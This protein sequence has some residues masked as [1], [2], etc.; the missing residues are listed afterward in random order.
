MSSVI[1]TSAQ[2]IIAQVLD[3]LQS[4]GQ[5]K[6][7]NLMTDT[8]Q[9]GIDNA[10]GIGEGFTLVPGTS[11][12]SVTVE[13]AGIAYDPLANRI[14]ISSSDTTLYN[15]ANPTT[16]TNDGTGTF[17]LTPQSTGCVNVPLTG[18]SFNYLW[19]DYL[20]TIDVTAF[21]LNKITQA[22]I[23]YEATDGYNIQVTTVNTP[24]DANSI[25]LGTINLS[26]IS[27]GIIPSSVIS[28]IGRQYFNILP[29]IVPITTA[30]AGTNPPDRTPHYAPASTYT[31]EAHIKAVGTGSGQSP[32]N[33]HNLSLADLGVSVI[34]TVTAHRQLEHQT[35]ASSGNAAANAII[36]GVPGTPSPSIS[37]MAASIN[38]VNPGSDYLT[39]FQLLS[40]E[41]AIINGTAYNVTDIFGSVPVNANVFF[42]NTSGTYNVYY[43]SNVNAFSLSTSDI[44]SD[45]TKLWLCTITYTYVGSGPSDHNS[46]SS[47]IDRRRIGSTTHLLQRWLTSARPGSGSTAAASGEFGFNLTTG[48][49][50]YW[51]GSVWQQPVTSSSNSIVPTGALLPFAGAAA[52]AG[53]LMANGSSQLVA[54]FP[55]LFAV[56]GYTYGG[57]GGNFNV[58][59]MTNYVPIGAGSIAPF[60]TTFGEANHTLT[61]AEIPA[62]THSVSDPSHV[63]TENRSGTGG[64]IFGIGS[65]ANPDASGNILTNATTQSAPTGI[66]I[67]SSGGSGGSHNNVQ[68]SLG[69]SYI[70]KT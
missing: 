5:S 27:S 61:T 9:S 14:F 40:S 29:N 60:G 68:P 26:S 19:I 56:I 25:F 44:S 15:S 64:S 12:L 51:D 48:L 53:F 28:Q 18:G 31:L 1:F 66:S 47:L 70:I 42:P 52:P 21:T 46:L 45:V 38:I 7:S 8:F 10:T 62:H 33:P 65:T 13:G 55:T 20:A 3:W 35:V 36:A 41:F 6:T 58:P 16:T 54:S 32:T 50:E 43:D 59:N 39:I 24:P 67:P 30:D 37:A 49:M 17:V 57:S 23:F 34:D 4:S 2:R 11:P 22:K 63:H 69:V